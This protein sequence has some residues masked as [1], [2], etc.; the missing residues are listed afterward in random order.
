MK[1]SIKVLACTLV[2]SIAFLA[3]GEASTNP[4]ANAV[5]PCKAVAKPSYEGLD[6]ICNSEQRHFF[7]IN[8]PRIID[9]DY[10]YSHVDWYVP[11][12]GFVAEEVQG[13]MNNP[14][15]DTDYIFHHALFP[16]GQPDIEAYFASGGRI[17]DYGSNVVFSNMPNSGSGVVEIGG[18]DVI[19]MTSEEYNIYK[20]EYLRKHEEELSKVG[21]SIPCVVGSYSGGLE[22]LLTNEEVI[23]LYKKYKEIGEIDDDRY[24]PIYQI[25][26]EGYELDNDE[27]GNECSQ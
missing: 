5:T 13:T 11:G 7:Y 8:S 23:E 22:A 26:A 9:L 14:D 24:M 19:Y 15:V 20:D 4:N 18:V 3:C 2:V 21:L 6:P 17:A 10:L 25:V 27:A 16:N 12:S 1:K